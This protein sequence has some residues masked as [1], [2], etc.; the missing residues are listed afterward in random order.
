MRHRPAPAA[1]PLIWAVAWIALAGRRVEPDSDR[2][3]TRGPDIKAG[4]VNFKAYRGLRAEAI[5]SLDRLPR[6]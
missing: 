6:I 1:P 3:R 4:T 5:W 2:V